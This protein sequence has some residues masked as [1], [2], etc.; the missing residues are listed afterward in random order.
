VVQ[1]RFSTIFATAIRLQRL[2]DDLARIDTVILV[3]IQAKL[4]V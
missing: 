1:E 2:M 3:V 4:I